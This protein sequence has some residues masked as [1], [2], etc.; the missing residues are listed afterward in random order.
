M[1][2]GVMVVAEPIHVGPTLQVP[3]DRIPHPDVIEVLDDGLVD[4]VA[5]PLD[6]GVSMGQQVVAQVVRRQ[7]LFTAF[8]FPDQPLQHLVG[9]LVPGQLALQQKRGP[10]GMKSGRQRHANRLSPASP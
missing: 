7:V 6:R 10:Q 3:V 9:R 5:Q 2:V 4:A 1:V 8:Q